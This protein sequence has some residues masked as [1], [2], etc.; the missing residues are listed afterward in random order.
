MNVSLPRPPPEPAVASAPAPGS[1]GPAPVSS[2]VPD[3]APVMPIRPF[4]VLAA[5]WLTVFAAS[6]QVIIVSPILPEIASALS[7][8]EG[9]LGWVITSYAACLGV[10]ALL[11]G[12]V[13]DRVGRRR[14]LLVGTMALTVAL[15]LHAFATTFPMLLAVRAL[16]GAAGGLLSGAAVAY[17]GDAFPYERR[18][19][20]S[21]WVMSGIAAGQVLGVPVGKGLAM[22]FGFQ[23]PFVAF[24]GLMVVAALLV[25]RYLPQPPIRRATSPLTPS[26]VARGYV[27]LVRQ[28]A[29]RAAML[30]YLLMFGGLGLFIPYFPT[31]LEKDVGVG[32]GEIVWLFLVGG[33][34]N[35]AAGPVAGRLSDRIGRLPMIFASCLIFAAALVATTYWV[36]GLGG[37]IVFFAVI[38][39][40]VAMRMAPL[41]S[42]LT[43]L[44]PDQQRGIMM[45]AA[46][47]V[48]QLGMALS[49]G[50]AGLL[51]GAYGFR[52]NSFGGAL[53]ILA[54]AAVVHVSL[55]E[56]VAPP[57]APV[58]LVPVFHDDA[59]H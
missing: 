12:P 59:V 44:V 8:P 11:A 32:G 38:M 41:Q 19:W 15:A 53:A 43:A 37:A 9:H 1:A 28:P 55:A 22:E 42:L 50:L 36:H 35:V 30:V 5:L 25:W 45:S 21:G 14:I 34:V 20:A 23:A 17:V 40:T 39:L 3:A 7:V 33:L 49:A 47:S 16:A 57:S 4:P 13:S 31:W 54:M 10:F 58:A 51:Y 24:A 46:I 48:G 26:A 52:A 56:P 27:D 6:S 18:G 2:D 29:P